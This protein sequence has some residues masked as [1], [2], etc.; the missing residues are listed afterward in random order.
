MKDAL[1]WTCV[2]RELK[3]DSGTMYS[4]SVELDENMELQAM[5]KSA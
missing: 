1:V 5:K 3:R 2:T 4:D